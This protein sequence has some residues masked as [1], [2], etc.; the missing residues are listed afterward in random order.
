MTW[1][2]ESYQD[3]QGR[4]LVNRALASL[5]VTDQARVLRVI[6]LLVD[7]GPALKMPH[8]RRLTGQLSELRMDGRPN[9][10][11]VIYAAVGEGQYLPLEL[12]AKKTQATPAREIDSA[13]R[14][15]AD[16]EHRTN[17]D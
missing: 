12:F 8:A 4:V 1:H 3:S 11:R 10:Y 2:V 6:E 5:S 9:S 13:R 17:H 7:Y 16:Y 15:L 14:R